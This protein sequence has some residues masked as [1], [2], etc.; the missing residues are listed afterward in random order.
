MSSSVNVFEAAAVG[1]IEYLKINKVQ[2]N[3]VNE[4]GW[5]SLHF[6]ARFGQ[7]QAVQYLIQSKVDP[8]IINHEGKT[9]YE[10][11]VF[12]GNDD[13]AELLKVISTKTE[14]LFPSPFPENYTA[15]FSG[16]PLNRFGWIRTKSE[17]LG[18]L[19][20]SPRSK[21]IPLLDLQVLYDQ[22]GKLHYLH[23]QDVSFLVDAVY[24]ANS[25]LQKDDGIILVF[26]GIDEREGKGEEGT[27]LWAID[28]TPVGAYQGELKRLTEELTSKE[29]SFQPTLPGAFKMSTETSALIAQ[30]AA[31]VDW[32][33][34]NRFCPGC[35]NQTIMDEGGHKRHCTPSHKD[36]C[37]SQSGI[38]NFT[39][40]RTGEIMRCP[41]SV[42]R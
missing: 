31:M 42:N 17:I 1:D 5:S 11:A 27:S 24:P 36:K 23:Y 7:K 12:W 20:R 28:V 4:R 14:E 2:L 19:A 41:V 8:S 6:A 33:K 30:S 9:A 35:G 34:R 16:N 10:V 25:S 38:Q 26:L 18:R 22:A 29:Y 32:N 13:I 37:I 39:Y 21:Y 40:P 15:L 3:S